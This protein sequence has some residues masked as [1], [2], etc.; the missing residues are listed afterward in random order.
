MPSYHMAKYLSISHKQYAL[1][2]NTLSIA[3]ISMNGFKFSFGRFEV[4]IFT[5]KMAFIIEIVKL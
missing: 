4:F 2:T 5:I 3:L 1:F